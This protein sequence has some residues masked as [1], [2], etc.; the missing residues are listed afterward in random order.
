MSAPLEW[1][2]VD[3]GLD[4]SHYTIATVPGRLQSMARRVMEPVITEAPDLAGALERLGAIDG[5]M[6]ELIERVGIDALNRLFP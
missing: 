6:Q 5:R 1:D 4:L 3:D 2:E